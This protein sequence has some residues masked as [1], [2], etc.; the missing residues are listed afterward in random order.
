MN[1]GAI[2]PK[3]PL[4][5]FREICAIPHGSR[6]TDAIADY[7]VR[8]AEKR[9]LFCLRDRNNNVIIKKP[10]A[11]GYEDKPSLI[12]QGHLDMVCE[13]EPDAVID[14]E[15][16]GLSLKSDGEYIF[17]EGTTLG[18]DDGIAVAMMLA[19]LDSGT[20]AHPALECIFTSDEEIG[21]IGAAALSTASL[22]GKTMLNLD[23]EDEGVFTVS[24]AGGATVTCTLPVSRE[25]KQGTVCEIIVDG[26]LGGHSGVEINLGRAN[27]NRLLA[28]AL[29]FASQK[30]PLR[31]ISISGGLKDNAIPARSAARILVDDAE[32]ISAL[33]SRFDLILKHETASC[34]PG[35]KIS[36]RV[37]GDETETVMSEKSTSDV[38]SFLLLAPNGVQEM[39]REI[40]G[41][42]ESSLNL[43]I[44]D[45]GAESLTASFS[46]R[47]SVSS[48]KEMMIRQLCRLT[49]LFGGSI[50]R[51]GDY[52]AWEY[53]KDSPLR[54]RMERIFLEQYGYAPK[55]EAIHAGLECGIFS[56]RIEGLDCVSCGPQLEGIHTPRE[57]MSIS[58]L[59]RFWKF[60]LEVL[61][62][63]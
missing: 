34:D 57:K 47:S 27:A 23:S 50:A 19:I 22:T 11:D 53:R 49:A 3:E 54:E 8:F 55:I 15:R 37:L 32:K 39:S 14:M 28:R 58:S 10:A 43:G 36:L 33:F 38:L 31:I 29:D 6:N 61:K 40:D 9:G 20:I 62:E 21:M 2:E 5:F 35:V 25:R 16:E 24:C 44:L 56:G 42:V 41:L 17:A 59:Q 63:S 7:C 46:V 18:A 45:C 12:L 13:K 52:P 26:L 30:Q 4:R 60:V 48:R 51:E 1:I